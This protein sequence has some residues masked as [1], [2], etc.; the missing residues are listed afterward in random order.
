MFSKR[1]KAFKKSL[2]FFFF[3]QKS[4]FFKK[5][6]K[7]FLST[8]FFFLDIGPKLTISHRFYENLTIEGGNF[9]ENF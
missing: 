4:F 9:V 5:K 3:F 6:L 2:R 7:S 8:I 1:L